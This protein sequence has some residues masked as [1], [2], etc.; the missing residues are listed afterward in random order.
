MRATR[1]TTRAAHAARKLREPFLDTDTPR[2][3][4]FAGDYPAY[5]LI[6]RERRNIL[7]HSPRRRRSPK[8]LSKVLRHGMDHPTLFSHKC[9]LPNLPVPEG[10]LESGT[11]AAE[12]LMREEASA[13]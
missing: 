4:F 3:R 8:S 12:A 10:Q 7:P 13:V 6:A 11:Q 1:P 5:P 9:I 2:L